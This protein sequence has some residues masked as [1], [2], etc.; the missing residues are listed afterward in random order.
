MSD[1]LRPVGIG[2]CILL[3]WLA[4]ATS[5]TG[6]TSATCAQLAAEGSARTRVTGAALVPAGA[7]TLPVQPGLGAPGAGPRAG[8]PPAAAASQAA[9]GIGAGPQGLGRNGGRR[10]A[11]YPELPAFCR[12]TATLVPTPTS[13]IRAELW[14]PVT[15]W[16]GNF[17]GSSPNAMGGNIPYG[18]MANALRD[19]YAI[20]GEDTG[21][22][23]NEPNWM[24]DQR[25]GTRFPSDP[26][27]SGEDMVPDMS[28]CNGGAGADTFDMY[29]AMQGW[30]QRKE[31]PAAILASRVEPDGRVSRTRPLCRYPQVATY[32]GAGSTD[33]ARNFNCR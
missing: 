7:F 9:R 28:E 3:I 27:C 25:R 11:T 6:Q 13:D 2:F 20:M 26:R 15:G 19:G 4:G 10:A 14:L 8:G 18:S 24:D 23:G 17:I 31:A 30:V 32:N 1:R 5:A 16:N 29:A 12:V 22:R 33:E 21:H